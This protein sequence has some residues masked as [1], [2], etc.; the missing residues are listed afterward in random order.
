LFKGY[1]FQQSIGNRHGANGFTVGNHFLRELLFS[2][3]GVLNVVP[4]IGNI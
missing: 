4:N 2:Q 1:T 3:L